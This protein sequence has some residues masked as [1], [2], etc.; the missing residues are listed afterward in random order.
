M[1]QPFLHRRTLLSGAVLAA[2]LGLGGCQA[3]LERQG[4][5]LPPSSGV[6]PLK[7][8]AQ[9]VSIRRNALGV[10]LIESHSFHDALFALG[11]V[12][13]SDRLQ[14]MLDLRLLAEGRLAE[15]AGPAALDGDR[16][17][18]ALNLRADARIVHQNAS[19]RLRQFLEVY[20]RGVNAYLFRQ[21]DRYSA[22]G[23][24]PAYWKAEDRPCCSACSISRWPATC[25][26]RSP[27]C[28][29]P[30]RSAPNNWPG[31]CRPTRTSRCRSTKPTSSRASPSAG[32]PERW[33]AWP[34]T[35]ATSP[36]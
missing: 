16:L 8:L 7:G 31:C 3:W 17:M 4:A 36:A 32:R 26:R 35:C 28:C 1:F 34:P 24:R 12:H 6:Q 10:P 5:D 15:R 27:A 22:G 18:R 14:Q 9:S 20:A 19:P 23:Y 30:T 21:R 33:P 29:W 25:R 11:Y 2:T 13:A